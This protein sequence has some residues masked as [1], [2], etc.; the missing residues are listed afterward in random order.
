MLSYPG[1][2]CSIE[3]PATFSGNLNSSPTCHPGRGQAEPRKILP[4]VIVNQ[5][6]NGAVS[7]ACAGSRKQ[8][9]G[10]DE[11]LHPSEH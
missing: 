7:S 9:P 10:G 2:N 3:I 6:Q 4:I 1:Q 5:V 11:E 8:T